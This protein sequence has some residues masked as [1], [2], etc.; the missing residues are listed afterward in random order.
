MGRRLVVH[1][2]FTAPTKSGA[3]AAGGHGLEPGQDEVINCLRG[4]SLE[5]TRSDGRQVVS[6]VPCVSWYRGSASQSMNMA[7]AV[8]TDSLAGFVGGR[9]RSLRRT[10]PHTYIRCARD[11]V[12]DTQAHPS[13]LSD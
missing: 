6:Q 1:D 4:C 2:G 10:L 5:P 12:D 7:A 3:G 9:E 8:V 13:V 11:V